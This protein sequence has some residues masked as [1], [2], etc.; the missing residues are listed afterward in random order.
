MTSPAIRMVVSG[1]RSSCDTSE[2][3]R[4]CSVDSSSMRWIWSWR[5]SAI[6]LNERA[7]VA[8]SSSPF[9]GIRSDRCPSASRSATSAARR[10]GR[11]VCR[12][13]SQ[14]MLPSSTTRATAARPSVRCRKSS[15]SCSDCRLY[16]KKSWYVPSTG[17]VT[18]WPTITPG[19]TPAGLAAGSRRTASAARR[20]PSPARSSRL[21]SGTRAWSDA[22]PGMNM[23]PPCW[24]GARSR[25]T[26][27]RSDPPVRC[28][29]RDVTLEPL[30]VGA[31]GR[32]RG[33]ERRPAPAAWTG[34]SPRAPG[35][36]GPSNRPSA[37]RPLT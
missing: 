24:P 17:T 30:H 3:N 4:R 13:T 29:R 33:V 2:T 32:R 35:R 22:A 1:V 18:S 8:I 37:M 6:S 21:T 25:N 10:T 5:L 20:P 28:A 14:V 15:R 34:R 7:S 26:S 31:G 11:T 12:V 16:R 27:R 19:D 23:S 9:S 36:A